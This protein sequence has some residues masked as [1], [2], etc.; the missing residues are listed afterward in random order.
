MKRMLW[1]DYKNKNLEVNMEILTKTDY[2]DIYRIIPGVLLIVN[3]F[4]YMKIEG[5]DY[6][7]IYNTNK[8]N[9]KNYAKGCQNDL[10]QLTQK[11]THKKS[12]CEPE[13]TLPKGTIMYYN[14][15]V[16]IASKD[17]W[18]YQIKTTGDAFSGNRENIMKLLSVITNIIKG[19]LK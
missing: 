2:Q 15:P 19:E 16:E 17:E 3:K 9:C 10:K 14:R 7:H 5:V 4:K 6:P 18:E 8:S 1:L 11:Y 13:W 12:W